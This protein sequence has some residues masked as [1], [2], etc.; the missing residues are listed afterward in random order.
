MLDF[1]EVFFLDI[2][3]EY[4][5]MRTV[6]KKET[7]KMN[8]TIENLRVNH[9]VDMLPFLTS[10]AIDRIIA[11]AEYELRERDAEELFKE[12]YDDMLARQYA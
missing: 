3:F 7:E 4:C 1:I 12:A 5:R 11:A 9:I 8:A 2:P 6:M 10:E